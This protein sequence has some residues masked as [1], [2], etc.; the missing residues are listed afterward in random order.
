MNYNFPGMMLQGTFYT[1]EEL[2]IHCGRR[3]KESALPEW[4]RKIHEFMI[5]FLDKNESIEQYSSGTTGTPKKIILSKKALVAS[6]LNTVNRLGLKGG[7]KALLCLSADY[8]AGKMMIV[9]SLVAG[10]NLYWEEPSSSPDLDRYEQIDFSAMVPLQVYGCREAGSLGK[11]GNLLIGGA[12][13]RRDFREELKKFETNIYETFGMAETCSHIA[14]RKISG[15]SPDEAFEVLPGV[16]VSVDDRSC[17]VIKTSYLDAEITTND[18][19]DLV[20]PEHFI[21]RG[22]ADN[23]INTGGIKVC[24]EELESIITELTGFDCAVTARPDEELGERI[25]LI[26]ESAG[27]FD[28]EL[29]LRVLK[30]N[31]SPYLV[32]KDCVS[33]EYLPRNNSYKIDRNA[34]SRIPIF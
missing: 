12:E 13:M 24:P 23:L 3:I 33:V 17:I 6:A 20:D 2:E 14:L 21:W 32:P 29:T 9:R 5:R 27:T 18:I 10:L 15:A 34:L 16:N 19:I 26:I 11:I 25:I 30:E 28:R 1:A 8:I 22:R 7:D 4:E 31:L